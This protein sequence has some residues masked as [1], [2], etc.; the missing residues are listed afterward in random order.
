VE[1]NLSVANHVFHNRAKFQSKNHRNLGYTKIR[2][3]DS[4]EELENVYCSL[5]LGLHFCHFCID[6][7]KTN[8]V[9][10]FYRLVIYITNYM[11]IYFQIFF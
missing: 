11:Q 9:L 10:K 7:I 2:K 1:K 5:V 6:Q 8:S 3:S 4:F